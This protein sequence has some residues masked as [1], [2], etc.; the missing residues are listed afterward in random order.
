MTGGTATSAELKLEKFDERLAT[1]PFL[2]WG[3]ASVQ[4]IHAGRMLALPHH[5][6][7]ISIAAVLHREPHAQS[8]D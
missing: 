3:A 7:D 6:R 4:R 2:Y 5:D 8:P 1:K